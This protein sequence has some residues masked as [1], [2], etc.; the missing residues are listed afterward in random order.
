MEQRQAITAFVR[1]DGRILLVRRSNQVGSFQGFWS[2]ISGYLEGEPL[3]H[4]LR[5]ILEETG[6]P[7][8]DLVLV[9]QADPVDIADRVRVGIV[10]RIHPF[11]F[12]LTSQRQVQLDWENDEL[13]W[14]L[15]QELGDYQTVPGLDRILSACLCDS[16]A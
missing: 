12:D 2:G 10:W 7:S 16:G 5:E 9:H 6:I 13:R 4:A 3:T 15:P 1:R 11:L 8:L 14:I